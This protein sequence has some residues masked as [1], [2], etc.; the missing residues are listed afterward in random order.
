[1]LSVLLLSRPVRELRR[2]EC[3]ELKSRHKFQLSFKPIICYRLLE[4]YL[5][6]GLHR[7]THHHW[8]KMPYRGTFLHV[9]FG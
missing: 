1:M 7:Q 8:T 6:E 2:I 3:V 4:A 5:V 9:G